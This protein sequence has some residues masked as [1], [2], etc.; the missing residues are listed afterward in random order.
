MFKHL[1]MN[2]ILGLDIGGSHLG[3]ALTDAGTGRLVEGTF[4]QVP[5][6]SSADSAGILAQWG[7]GIRRVLGT[8]PVTLLTGIGISMPGPFDYRNGISRIRGLHKYDAL[9]GMDIR[10]ALQKELGLAS[11][12]PVLFQNDAICFGLGEYLAGAAAG[13]GRVVALTLGTGMGAAFLDRGQPVQQGQ[14]VPP[15]GTLYQLPFG[16]GTAEDY[17][18]GRGVKSLYQSLHPSEEAGAA[19]HGAKE[20]Y[21]RALRQEQTAL[22][23]WAE[24]SRSLGA[25][26]A[27]WQKSF[28]ADLL[29]LGGSVSKA[30]VFFLEALKKELGRRKVKVAVTVSLLGEKAAVVGAASLPRNAPRPVPQESEGAW[31]CSSQPLLPVTK[32]SRVPDGYDLYPAFQ[33]EGGK[34]Y[35]GIESLAGY[36]KK[37]KTVMI[38]GYAGVFWHSLAQQLRTCLER[39]GLRVHITETRDWFY[40]PGVIDAFLAPFLGAEGD[41]W[42]SRCDKRL[43]DFFDPEKIAATK[44]HRDADIHIVIGTG[45]GLAGWECPLIY[46]ELPKNEL[47]YRMRAGSICNLGSRQPEDAASMY[48]RFYFVDW[49]V[50]NKHK[51]D[52]L[53]RIDVIVDAQ[54][55]E[56]V[57]WMHARELHAALDTMSRNVLRVRPWFEPGAWGGQWLKNHLPGIATE[58]VNYAWSFELITPENGL[59]LESGGLLLEVSFDLLMYTHG[60]Q[61]L[62]EAFASR[63]GDQFPIRFDFLDTVKGGNLSIQCHPSP[64]YIRSHFG[65]DF[66]Q[67]ETYYILDA[68]PS[69]GVYLGFQQDIRPAEFREALERSRQE[70]TAVDISRYVQYHPAAVHDLFLIPHGTVHSAGAGNLVLEIS[71]TPYIFTFKMYDWLRLDLDGRPRPINI[72]H[73]FNNLDF[74]RKGERVKREL[75]S[76]PRLLEEGE[77]WKLFHL[78]T[79]PDHFYDVHRYEF[80]GEVNISTGGSCQ[81]LMVVEGAG[82]LLETQNGLSGRFCYAETFVVPAAAGSYRL[83]AEA[84]ET[85][86]VVKAFLKP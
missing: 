69:A 40:P 43:R 19:P 28:R 31:R 78:P 75:I 39:G 35:G 5:I 29:V 12:A 13:C 59:L 17:F 46:V 60:R 55:P 79:H 2:R 44:P 71:A 8:V 67:D 58:V 6:D 18:S 30:S 9:Y 20:V 85:V 48:K 77:G 32:P 56:A 65:E 82:V 38:D 45:A 16:E 7:E 50:L 66:T 81:V 33:L 54:R 23:T 86:K 25:F 52:I 72:G 70:N 26:L 53:P 76:S 41:V 47:Q 15:G 4:H 80:T 10:Q 68:E 24:F 37:C 64:A 84:G 3:G 21:E 63:F 49:V 73:A 57:T 27:P 34:I 1:H 22:Q 42:G 83:R 14:E 11:G 36:I 74:S 61:V 51:K 62:G